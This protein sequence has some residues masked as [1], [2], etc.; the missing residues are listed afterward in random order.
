M[1]QSNF[2]EKINQIILKKKYSVSIVDV[3][4]SEKINNLQKSL[5]YYFKNIVLLFHALTHKSA[6][7]PETDPIGL[8]SNERL[9]LLGDSILDFLVTE[10]LYNKFPG[11]TEG[12]ITEIKSMIVSRKIIGDVADGINLKN[13]MIFGKSYEN[14][15]NSKTDVCSNAF[16]ALIAAIYLDGGIDC[17]RKVLRKKLFPLIESS[18]VRKENINYKTM[19]LEFVQG[20]GHSTVK[21]NLI[22]EKGPDHE[23]IFTVGIEING[24]DMGIAQGSSKKDAEQKA[25]KIAAMKLGIIV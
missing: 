25:A 14:L 13:A 10:E 7:A 6:I 11:Y 23:K 1:K 12:Q 19:I 9:E 21:Y 2:F 8:G 15:K 5:G 20:N 17:I 18:L 4:F 3:G 22:S 16:E 24:K